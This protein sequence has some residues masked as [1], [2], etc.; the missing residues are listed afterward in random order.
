M[1]LNSVGILLTYQCAIA[2]RHC[3]ISCGPHRKTVIDLDL[4]ERLLRQIKEIGLTGMNVHIGGGEAFPA[5]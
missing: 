1:K 5:F 4:A 2:C 3:Y